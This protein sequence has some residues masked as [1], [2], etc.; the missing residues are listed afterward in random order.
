MESILKAQLLKKEL[1]EL[2]PLLSDA[3]QRIMQKFRLDWNYHSNSLEGNA[4][5]YGETRVFLL[6]HITAQGKPLKDHLEIKGHNDAILWIEEVVKQ[7][8]PLT[9]QFIRELH[10]LVL[11]EPYEVDAQ[12]PDGA[13][14][15]KRI[16]PGQYKTTPN[17]VKTRTGEIFRFAEP[18]E[19]P[20][21][22]GDLI[23][24]YRKEIE[25]A[26]IEPILL[27]AEFH[28]RFV[29]IHPF[30]DGNGRMARILMNFI[31]MRFGYPP[32]I[33]KA[34]E[35][36]KY[37]SALQQADGS[38]FEPFL[39]FIA[40][41]LVRSLETMLSGAKGSSIEE[42]DDIDKEIKLM[43]AQFRNLESN[44]ELYRTPE[45]VKDFVIN[46]LNDLGN[47]IDAA[48]NLFKDYFTHQKISLNARGI[49]WGSETWISWKFLTAAIEKNAHLIKDIVVINIEF[50]N[51]RFKIFEPLD[52]RM[53]IVLNFKE[54]RVT[55]ETPEY[56][57]SLFYDERPTDENVRQFGYALKKQGQ[58]QLQNIL[59]QA[60]NN[61]GKQS[62]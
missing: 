3:E 48:I 55:I 32:V 39:E 41:N 27:A 6:H 44:I 38:I 33:I 2:R 59:D 17:H 1:D 51:I 5:T 62:S 50:K 45:V 7:E 29:R 21:K 8:R 23:E 25:K 49:G 10:K 20:A 14:T 4:L 36:E 60:R 13:P 43:E 30:D 31:L 52:L 57:F 9:E 46:N 40:T 22:M 42:P 56:T 47:Q 35:K 19:T 28:Y 15:K 54:D 12:T 58:R 53:H 11:G 37:F 18:E 16:Q 24:W 61:Q 26:D 34:E